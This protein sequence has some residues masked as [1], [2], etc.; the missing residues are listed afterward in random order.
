MLYPLSYGRTERVRF[1]VP[2]MSSILSNSG[3]GCTP[4]SQETDRLCLV[5]E[6]GHLN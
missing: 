3:V 2:V 6:S 1:I 5:Q 4:K